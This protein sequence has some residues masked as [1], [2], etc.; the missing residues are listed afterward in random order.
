MFRN[1]EFLI[2]EIWGHLLAAILLTI[3][4]GWFLW[5]SRARKQETEVSRL[6]SDL[7]RTQSELGLKEIELSRA[8][9]KQEQLKDR[10]SAFQARLSE[11]QTLQKAAEEAAAVN[12][13]K[14]SEALETHKSL[15]QQL[16]EALGT[17]AVLT[18][19]AEHGLD[20]DA[21]RPSSSLRE[22]V[23]KGSRYAANWVKEAK[24]SL[25]GKTH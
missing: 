19:A 23:S 24:D 10:M 6:R 14:L 9:T 21:D 12:Q 13:S 20:E 3:A 22:R 17:P 1:W 4:L 11:S 5:G 7:E 2:A 25:F 16:A 15:E 8:F 18:T